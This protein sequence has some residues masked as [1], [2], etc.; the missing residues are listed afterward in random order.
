MM[1]R[2]LKEMGASEEVLLDVYQKHMRS[3]LELAVP[4]W[5]VAISQTD[6]NEI[7]CVQKAAP[8]LCWVKT[9]SPTKVH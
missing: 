1:V 9:T 3:V 4:A 2:R 8:I 5:H 6:R 7:E